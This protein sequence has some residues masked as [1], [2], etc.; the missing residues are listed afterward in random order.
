MSL[1][2]LTFCFVGARWIVYFLSGL[3]G[4]ILD[5]YLWDD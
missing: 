5:K 4:K 2:R 3:V 1:L